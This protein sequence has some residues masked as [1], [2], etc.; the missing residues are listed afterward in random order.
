[1]TYKEFVTKSIDSL[2]SIY[3]IGESKAIAVRV[4]THFL[5]ITDYE[6]LVDPNVIIPKSDVNILQ[7]AVDELM[8]SRPVQYVLGYEMFA[9]HKFNVSESVL[10]PR[11]ETEEMYRLI[12]EQWRGGASG[13]MK[14]LDACTGS[15]CLAYSLAAAFPKSSVLACD[16]YEDALK[17]AS[18]QQVF[19]DEERRQPLRNIPL[20]FK[21]D[22]LE[23][24]PDENDMRK[25]PSLPE[26]SELDVLVSNPPYV[27]ERERD[28]MSDNVLEYEP[29]A[30]LFVPDNDPLR[31]YKALAGWASS[32]LKMG[33]KG[34]FEIN[35]AFSKEVVSL[36][37]SF[38]F[39][40]VTTV[41]DIH[42]KPRMV[43]FTKWF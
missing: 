14:I 8:E 38:G 27:C 33:G 11:P 24:P 28:F 29:D 30:A 16:L 43:Y 2:S 18:S 22:V 17:V 19:L 26:L 10:I 34:Y 12:V 1:M 4:L 32:L 23:G 5:P 40:E 31:F 13:D 42:D 7:G 21:W 36:F 3:S 25:D 15:G 6:Y 9:G 39:S 35:E 37:E 20:F 41:E